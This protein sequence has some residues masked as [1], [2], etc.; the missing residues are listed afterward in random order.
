MNVLITGANGFIGK[1][2]VVHLKELGLTP[3][4]FTRDNSLEDLAHLLEKSEFIVH[5]AGE[6]RPVNEEH[7]EAVNAGLTS[8]ICDLVSLSGANTPIL[9]ASSIQAEVNNAY[10][11]SKLKAELIVKQFAKKTGNDTYICRLQGVFGKWCKPN[12]NSVVATFCHNIT[13]NLSVKVNDPYA[14]VRLVYID[15]VVK[16]FIKVIQTPHNAKQKLV[17]K[18][19]YKIELGDL[20]NQIKFFSEGRKSLISD[21]VGSGLIR[22]LYSTYVSY[23]SPEQFAYSIPIYRD[24]RGIF[25]EMLKTKD[26]GQ[27]SFFTAKPGVTRGGHY[28]HSKTEKFLVIKGTAR[29]C[30]RNIITNEI[31]ELT[32]FGDEP[33]VVETVPGWAHDVTNIGKD[34]MIAMLWANEVFDPVT[35]DTLACKV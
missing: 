4:P 34:E 16:E 24:K 32:T 10:G 35:P 20:A 19:E 27:F 7:F 17:I 25:V 28:H 6:N 30:F 3:L 1:N 23:L 2:L 12:Y 14:E 22:K 29:F 9:L 15:D 33:K 13:H 18:P 8:K 5:L 31:C 26:S 21:K 11:A